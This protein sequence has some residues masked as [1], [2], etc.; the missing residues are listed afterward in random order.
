MSKRKKQ[1]VK[2]F[3]RTQ[4]HIYRVCGNTAQYYTGISWVK[5]MWSAKAIVGAFI[6][7]PKPIGI[8]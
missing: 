4:G 1:P 5:S 3:M 8:K 6:P 2:Y 7:I